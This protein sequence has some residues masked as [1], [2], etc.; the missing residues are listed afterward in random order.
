M[1]KKS[2]EEVD[3]SRRLRAMLGTTA[4]YVPRVGVETLRRFND[5]LAAHLPFPF[6]AKLSNPVG[7][8][9]DT[10]SPLSVLRLLDPIRDYAPDEMNGLICK[11]EQNE[12]R[13]E[14]PLD[15]IDVDDGS[16]LSQLLE[17]Y[18][19]WLWNCQ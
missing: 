17:D 1:R 10:E 7:P 13:I 3:C 4:Q 18:R 5:Y 15:R 6:E 8:H 19:H 2:Q 9:R 11:V 12:V 14:L 16:P